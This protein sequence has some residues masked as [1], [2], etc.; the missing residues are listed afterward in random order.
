MTTIVKDLDTLPALLRYPIVA[1]VL[2]VNERT[3]RRLG[4]EGQLHQVA[5]TRHAL[6]VTKASVLAFIERGGGA[7]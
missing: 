5:I 1:Q 7:A 2:D 6:R 4:A 3:A